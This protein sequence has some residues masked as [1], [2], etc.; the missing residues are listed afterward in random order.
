M[1]SGCN[2][3]KFRTFGEIIRTGSIKVRLLWTT[4]HKN[5]NM[6]YVEPVDKIGEVLHLRKV[7]WTSTWPLVIPIHKQVHSPTRLTSLKLIFYYSS[8]RWKTHINVFQYVHF[9]VLKYTP[10]NNFMFSVSWR[11]T[12]HHSYYW[13]DTLPQKLENI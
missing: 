13:K 5:I 4:L 10:I 1:A 3:R 7:L 2:S 11:L 6:P 9:N 12:E 8:Q